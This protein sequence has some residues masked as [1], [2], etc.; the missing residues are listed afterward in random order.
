[1]VYKRLADK[2][3]YDRPVAE[4]PYS[5]EHALYLAKLYC[6]SRNLSEG[7]IEQ[8]GFDVQTNSPDTTLANR[9]VCAGYSDI[10]KNALDMVGIES[11]IDSG[12]ANYN[13]TRN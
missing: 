8:E 4:G 9:T 10:L 13:Q 1:V 12:N 5:K 6:K 7:L 3:I 2:I 11:V